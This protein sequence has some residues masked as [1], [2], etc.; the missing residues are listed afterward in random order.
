MTRTAILAQTFID[1]AADGAVYHENN[2]LLAENGRVVG[3]EPRANLPAHD[4]DLQ[5]LD[6]SEHV[7]IPGLIDAG[8]LPDQMLGE[9]GA[10]P[11][12]YGESVWQVKQAAEAWLATGVTTVASMG[13]A[14]RMDVDLSRALSAGRMRGP[15]VLPALTPLVPAGSANFH[16]LYGVREVAGANEARRAARELIKQGADR[17]VVYADPPL[18][19]DPDPYETSRHRMGFSVDELAEIVTQARQAGCYVHAQAISTQAIQNCIDAGV[20]SIGCAF[21]LTTEQLP[22]LAAKNIALAPNLALGATIREHGPVL[23][24]PAATIDMVSQQRIAPDVL[25]QARAAGVQIIC[26]TNAALMQGSVPRE[27]AELHQ[28][29]LS[30]ETV[31]RAVT[32]AAADAL[33]PFVET[34]TFDPNRHADCVILSADPLQDLNALTQV[35][36]VLQAGQPK[37]G[38]TGQ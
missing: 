27:C 21:G 38:M 24:L 3:F 13:A 11:Q 29:G 23:G 30:S 7:C 9:H 32:V 25:Q 37:L 1:C 14:E 10:R 31:L 16:W 4:P 33:K 12:H 22:A 20:R 36:E 26:A 35:V 5:I 8:F 17:I 2:Y 15:R 6:Y 34:G 18:A 28:A 19:F